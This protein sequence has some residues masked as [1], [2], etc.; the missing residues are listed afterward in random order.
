MDNSQ[1][2]KIKTKGMQF[3]NKKI[4]QKTFKCF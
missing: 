4:V 3:D 1:G 2:L